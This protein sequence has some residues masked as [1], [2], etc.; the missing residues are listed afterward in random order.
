MP[1]PDPGDVSDLL[2]IVQAQTITIADQADLL[3]RYQSI[4][5]AAQT[6]LPVA[7][8]LGSSAGTTS[9]TVT[10]SSGSIV[11][12]AKVTGV[13]IPAA[14]PATTIVSGPG[15]D[16][17]YITNQATTVAAGTA[18]AFA[19]PSSASPWPTPQD[20][21]TLMLILQNQTALMRTQAAAIQHYQ[22]V[23]NSSQTPAS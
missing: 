8:G 21:P 16:G 1:W 14:P 4:L 9:L 22:D 18:L 13:G 10:G 20:A 6:M 7:T 2:G 5:N 19:P 23:L 3:D 17:T 11:P 15:G 12:G